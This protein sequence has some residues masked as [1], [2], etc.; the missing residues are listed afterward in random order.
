MAYNHREF[1]PPMSDPRTTGTPDGAASSPGLELDARIDELLLAGLDHYFG[2]RFQEAIDVWGR[3]LFLDRGHAR[4]RAY[5]ERARGALAERQ[6]RSEELVHDGV[7]ALQRGD[8][9]SARELLV[10]AVEEGDA[11]DMARAYLERLERL[12]TSPAAREAAREPMAPAAAPQALTT[13]A[14]LGR[15]RPPIRVLP[16]VGLALIAAVIIA[17]ATSRDLLKPLLDFRLTRPGPGAAVTLSPDPLP[18]PRAAE[19]SVSRAKT[20]FSAGQLKAALAELDAVPE[21]DPLSGEAD[22]LRASIQR[23]LLETLDGAVAGAGQGPGKTDVRP[24]QR[25]P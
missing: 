22:R 14:L 18:V 3:V 8:G 15:V 17:F 19:V 7:A 10:S 5:I 16:L 20:M 12:S 24:G 11:H 13:R 1:P 6:R 21:A 23:A 25:R 4:A 2:G 9:A